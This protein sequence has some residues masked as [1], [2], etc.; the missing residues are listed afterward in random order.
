[1]GRTAEITVSSRLGAS[2]AD[3]WERVTTPEGINDEMRPYLRMTIP[4]GVEQLD[5]ESIEIGKKVGRSWI[6]LFGWIPAAASSSV[7]RCSASASGN[8]SGHSTTTAVAAWSPTES[9]GSPALACPV[10]RCD[11]PSAPSSATAIAGCAVGLAE[12]A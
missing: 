11:P 5:L 12:W 2:P 7:R 9:V 3:V 1:M 8:T 4:R 10:P 6:L